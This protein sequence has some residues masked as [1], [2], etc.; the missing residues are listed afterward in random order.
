MARAFDLDIPRWQE[1]T[2]EVLPAFLS[3][4]FLLGLIILSATNIALATYTIIGYALLWMLKI[5]GYSGRL[6]KGYSLV[7]VLQNINWRE[8]L[9]DLKSPQK[10]QARVD[11]E[12]K[13]VSGGQQIALKNYKRLLDQAAYNNE[14]LNPDDLLHVVI[15]AAYNESKDIIESTIEAV[16]ANDYNHQQVAVLLA[17]EQRGGA[18]IAKDARELQQVY[19]KSFKL[20]KAIEHPA[21]I[22][23]EVKGKGGNITFAGR[24]FAKYAEKNNINPEHVIVTTLDS[25]NRPAKDYLA[26]LSYVYCVVDDRITKSFQPMAMFMNN[27]WDVPALSRVIATN[28]SFWLLME[29]MRPHRLRNFSA[30]AQSLAALLETDFWNVRSIV[31]DGHQYWRS[32]FIFNG[33]HTVVPLFTAIY[34]DAVLAETYMKTFY[35]QFKQ[36][37]RWAWGVSDTP[38]VVVNM[39]R[40][41]TIPLG[42]RL[43]QLFRQIEGYFSWATASIVL[44]AGGWLPLLVN[45]ASDQS[46][47]ISQLP[48]LA[49]RIQTVALLGLLAPVIASIMSFPPL[50]KEYSRFRYL[51]IIWQW[52]LI[53]VAL[54]GFGSVAALNAQT[55]LAINK[56]LEQF[57]V[58]AKFR[59]TKPNTDEV[60]S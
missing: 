57:D 52:L 13:S 35:E 9:K 32:Y 49:S 23:G 12:L 53:P 54:I 1:R 15:I 26:Y 43:I 40:Y 6:V 19:G 33:N 3:W 42:Q 51:S 21:D 14:T 36:L 25:D 20:F 5:I 31:E 50:P 56:P 60:L 48:V 29:A 24:W 41:K 2:L 59:K 38:F 46:L 17:Y 27:I 47:V 11:Q 58:T 16:L 55:R 4:G 30:H 45:S 18:Q 37:R 8:R 10:A 39:I 7:R 28:N 22:P 44:V 34:Q